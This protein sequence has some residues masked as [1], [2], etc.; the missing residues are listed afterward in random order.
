IGGE[1]FPYSSNVVFDGDASYRQLFSAIKSAGTLEA[2]TECM[3]TLRRESVAAKIVLAASFASVL[4]E[5][6]GLLPF[7]VHLWGSTSGT[8]K[9][10]G[11]MAAASVWGDPAIGKYIQTF[12][13]TAVGHER[14]AAFLNSLPVIIDELQLADV[15]GAGDKAFNVYRLA[16][17]VGKSRGNRRGGVD[18]TPTWANTILT[19]G[20]TPIIGDRAASGARNRVIEIECGLGAYVVR[21]GHDVAAI[22]KQNHGTAGRYFIEHLDLD[23]AR[24]MYQ[25]RF[26]YFTEQATDKQAM[27]AACLMVADALATELIFK[28][29]QQLTAGELEV[30]LQTSAEVDANE[31]AWSFI[32]DWVSQNSAAFSAE[33]GARD[34]F[35]V[36]DSPNLDDEIERV[37]IIKSVFRDVLTRAGF[38][39]KSFQAWLAAQ[40]LLRM[41]AKNYTV[42]KHIHGIRTDVYDLKLQRPVPV[43]KEEQTVLPF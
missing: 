3:R 36:F 2:W 32:R 40:G 41:Q 12:H 24:E 21:N 26:R 43:Q 23:K 35:G 9:T 6:L 29:G 22:V 14:L 19:S 7:F 38:S 31:R 10:V 16:E 37:F 15:D 42:V 33:K 4:I 20:E 28:D 30:F 1:F 18:A 39:Y 17:G 8:G 25:A 5:P 27:A 13:S 34:C 11:L